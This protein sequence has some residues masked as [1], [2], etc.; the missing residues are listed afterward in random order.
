MCIRE[1]SG[2]KIARKKTIRKEKRS[3]KELRRN[4]NKRENEKKLRNVC[5]ETRT[6]VKKIYMREKIGKR[7]SK[8]NTILKEK[9]KL[10]KNWKGKEPTGKGK[11]K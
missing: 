1:K 7:K 2:E 9:R 10:K 3:K 11:G 5:K 6:Q 4:R 8:K